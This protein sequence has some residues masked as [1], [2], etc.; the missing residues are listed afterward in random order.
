MV[1]R[2]L[3]RLNQT[4][5]EITSGTSLDEAERMILHEIREI[6]ECEV[7]SIVFIEDESE[8][9]SIKK[10]LISKEGWIYQTRF[11]KGEGLAGICLVTRK[12]ILSNNPEKLEG[13]KKDVDLIPG[14]GPRSMIYLPLVDNGSSIGLIQVI[15]KENKIFDSGDQL[16]LSTLTGTII[17]PL[18]LMQMNE[19][20]KEKYA[21]LETSRGELIRSRNT[22]RSLFDNLPD[23]LYIIDRMY[24][25]IAI[26]ASRANRAN[27]EPRSLV[28]EIC[29]K[30]LFNRT[31][32]CE[33]CLVKATFE[34]KQITNRNERDQYENGDAF[35]WEINTYPIYDD[36]G[37]IIQVILFEKDI[38][39]RHRMEM[40]VAQSEKMA[41]VGQ[42]AAGIAHE[43]NNPLTVVLANAQ[44]LMREL[45]ETE[46]WRELAELIN[47]AGGRA[48]HTVRNLLDFA[49]REQIDFLTTNIN[50]TIERALEMLHHEFKDRSI[51]LDY[52]PDRNMQS[53]LASAVNLQSVWV[54]LIMN[55][56]DSIYPGSGKI[57]LKTLQKSSEI[58]VIISDDG[59]GIPP[60]SL[61]RIF[62]PFYT[63]KDPGKGTGLG[64]SICHRIVKQHGGYIEVDSQIGEGTTFTVVL[65]VY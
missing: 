56:M 52:Q 42:L 53:I 54:N 28:G 29:F 6:M 62:E 19:K 12:V 9:S 41:A 5:S 34:T 30:A 3:A 24:R 46:D 8:I 13:Y 51:T 59:R 36:Q 10:S 48:L 1:T 45:P 65:P 4:L 2:Y 23:S 57:T 17:K 14:L 18:V 55:A 47:N 60:D 32:P 64:L 21:H 44:I 16:L 40:M 15:N 49:R 61:G 39:E 63:T 20:L 35:D 11:E 27:A 50:E 26:N 38:T 33:N 58:W 7:V 43:I 31:E 37:E 22:L 25:I